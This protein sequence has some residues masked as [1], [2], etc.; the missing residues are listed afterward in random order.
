MLHRFSGLKFFAATALIAS[1]AVPVFAEE[2][3]EAEQQDPKN[4]GGRQHAGKK[5][6]HLR[7]TLPDAPTGQWNRGRRCASR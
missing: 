3:Q 6:R 4:G 7:V 2:A 5:K 1:F